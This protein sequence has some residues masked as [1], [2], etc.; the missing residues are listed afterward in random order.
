[1]MFKKADDGRRVSQKQDDDGKEE[2]D[3][4][5]FEIDARAAMFGD[6]PVC[7]HKGQLLHFLSSSPAALA[8][9]FII[10]G[11]QQWPV[12]MNAGEERSCGV[13][14]MREPHRRCAH[15]LTTE[16]RTAGQPIRCPVCLNYG[17]WYV[18]YA[19]MMRVL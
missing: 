8:R 17:E 13:C 18:D 10:M 3:N 1:M 15:T 12:C 11:G 14:N 7:Y 9:G 19:T 16:A 4:V 6:C 5:S 2:Q